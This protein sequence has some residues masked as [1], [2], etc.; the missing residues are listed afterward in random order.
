[1]LGYRDS[2]VDVIIEDKDMIEG[3]MNGESY[4]VG[5][6][7]HGLRFHLLREHLG[8]LNE[9]N[10][11][12][13]LNVKDPVAYNFYKG[14]VDIANSNTLIFER[15]FQRRILPTNSIWNFEDLENWKTFEGLADA[16][17]EEARKEL[18]SVSGQTS[19]LDF[20]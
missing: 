17:P 7:S 2:E 11:D 14:V 1:M 19:E 9:E 4:L 8:L 3:Q 15:I 12:S 5:K 20:S 10:Q 6:F 18:N 13:S 16:F